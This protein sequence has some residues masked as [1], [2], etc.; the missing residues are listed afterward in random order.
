MHSYVTKLRNQYMNIYEQNDAA[1]RID[2][3]DEV[4]QNAI[5]INTVLGLGLDTGYLAIIVYTHDLF[6]VHRNNHHDLA[7]AHLLT[8]D[9]WYMTG[10]DKNTR[11][12][13]ANAVREHRASYKGAYSSMLSEVLASADKGAP[14]NLLAMI[15]R[16]FMYGR[17]KLALDT[18]DAT[19]H[20][21]KHMH[22]KF[23]RNGYAKYPSIYH[24]MYKADLGNLWDKIDRLSIPS[25]KDVLSSV[26]I[27][28]LLHEMLV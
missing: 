6:A 5:Q 26:S 19:I 24:A 22:E 3:I 17:T 11:I 7:A 12:L 21:F 13:L 20:A 28:S 2:H 4:Y 10:I 14:T 1:H 25:E 15:E 27:S 23:G 16:S 18:T 9:E 8:T